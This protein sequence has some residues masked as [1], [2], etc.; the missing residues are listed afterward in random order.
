VFE[1]EV[2]SARVAPPAEATFPPG[3]VRPVPVRRQERGLA[4]LRIWI[5]I[6][7]V[8]GAQM[9]WILRPFIGSPELPFTWFRERDSNFFAAFLRALR[10]LLF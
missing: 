7:A 6:Y 5:L 1:I 2:S 8:V 9:G 3:V 4:V 10:E